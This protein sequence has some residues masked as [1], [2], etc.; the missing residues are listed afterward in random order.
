MDPGLNSMTSLGPPT[1]ISMTR[2]GP[3]TLIS[4]TSL[5]PT[6]LVSMTIGTRIFE[7]KVGKR[8]KSTN[9]KIFTMFIV[10]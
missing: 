3:P 10:L 1:P 9:F 7:K 8:V 5:G 2:L 4:M 6:T